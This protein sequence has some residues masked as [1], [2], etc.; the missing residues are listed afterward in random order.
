[1]SD[2]SHEMQSE[3][4]VP[5]EIPSCCK[6]SVWQLQLNFFLIL[7]ISYSILAWNMTAN[8]PF[9]NILLPWNTV[10][11]LLSGSNFSPNK[12]P[13]KMDGHKSVPRSILWCATYRRCSTLF[14]FGFLQLMQANRPDSFRKAVRSVCLCAHFTIHPYCSVILA[15]Q[16]QQWQATKCSGSISF[17]SGV[18]S[19]HCADA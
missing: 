8:L 17:N 6:R 15:Q 13:G 16:V 19:Q 2:S 5:T 11:I 12:K 7:S 10:K 14:F 18:S 3:A 1:M 9:A 4:R